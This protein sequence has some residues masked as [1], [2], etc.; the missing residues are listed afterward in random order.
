VLRR[1]ARLRT[2]FLFP[3]A[4][5][6]PHRAAGLHANAHATNTTTQEKIKMSKPVFDKIFVKQLCGK[7]TLVNVL[8]GYTIRT[9]KELIDIIEGI[10]PDLQILLHEGR[11]LEDEKTL[12]SYNIA[13][14]ATLYLAVKEYSKKEMEDPKTIAELVK[15]VAFNLF[16]AGTNQSTDGLY[17]VF[18]QY[19]DLPLRKVMNQER[20]KHKQ[21]SSCAHVKQDDKGLYHEGFPGACRCD[22]KVLGIKRV[23][24]AVPPRPKKRYRHSTSLVNPQPC[25]VDQ[26]GPIIYQLQSG[27]P[28]M[29]FRC[30]DSFT[31]CCMCCNTTESVG[32]FTYGES[33][34]CKNCIDSCGGKS[35]RRCFWINVES[36]KE[37]FMC[38]VSYPSEVFMGLSLGDCDMT[39]YEDDDEKVFLTDEQ[40]QDLDL[41]AEAVKGTKEEVFL[42]V[43]EDVPELPAM[44]LPPEVAEALKDVKAPAE[45]SSCGKF[46]S[47]DLCLCSPGDCKY[48]K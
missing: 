27:T 22:L 1:T 33:T 8:P 5:L 2:S 45:I 41:Y 25:T 23:V 37:C 10:H 34:L 12:A 17:Y 7:R 38:R 28:V 4:P 13:A 11:Q 15:H 29:R 47:P 46:C 6:V 21:R 3:R 24:T 36:A 26:D 48:K 18:A 35:C 16:D 40:M 30:G 32:I 31:Q 44:E 9:V 43:E 39:V 42:S 19:C 14:G 20:Y